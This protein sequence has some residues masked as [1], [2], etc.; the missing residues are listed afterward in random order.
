MRGSIASTAD[1]LWFMK[2]RPT[3]SEELARPPSRDRSNSAAELTAPAQ[4]ATSLAV[5]RPRLAVLSVLDPANALAVGLDENAFRLRADAKL[6]IRMRERRLEAAGLG[7]HLAAA[8]IGKRV[9][10]RRRALQPG[11]DVDAERQRERMQADA[12]HALANGGDRRF[13]GDRRMRI[14]RRMRGLGRIVAE[15]AAHLIERLGAAVPGLHLLVGERP[16]RRRAFREL[17][18][19]EIL[20]PIADQDRAVELR[21]A[22]DVIVIAGIERR[23]RAVDPRLLGTKNAALKDRARVARVGTVRQRT[24]PRSRMRMRAPVGA[25]PAASVAPPMP[26]PMMTTSTVSAPGMTLALS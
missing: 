13:V 21:V 20:R 8:R 19:G 4:T 10:R 26:E 11:F 14:G 7:V 16:A 17:G 6:D 23:A 24:S 22:A 5:E 1:A 9:P 25:S 18:G 2:W 3:A 15:R 12:L